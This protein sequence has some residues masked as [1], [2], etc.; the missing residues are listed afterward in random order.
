[1]VV[2]RFVKLRYG[3]RQSGVSLLLS[4]AS[5]SIQRGVR[6]CVCVEMRRLAKS[7]YIYTSTYIFVKSMES[8]LIKQPFRSLWFT[9]FKQLPTYAGAA[10]RVSTFAFRNCSMVWCVVFIY[11]FVAKRGKII[12]FDYRPETWWPETLAPRQPARRTSNYV[13]R[14]NAHTAADNNIIYA[15]IAHHKVWIINVSAFAAFGVNVGTVNDLF[16]RVMPRRTDGCV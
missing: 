4:S 16:M 14:A 5:C 2:V 3:A 1:M 12:I 6:V 9:L 7:L 11:L 13:S 10:P 15:R 8:T